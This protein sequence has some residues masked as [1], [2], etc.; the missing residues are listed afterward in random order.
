MIKYR[1]AVVCPHCGA[2]MD[3]IVSVLSEKELGQI[4]INKSFSWS[5]END[6]R[7]RIGDKQV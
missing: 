3:S 6:T 2:R 1:K 7:G 4:M 5:H